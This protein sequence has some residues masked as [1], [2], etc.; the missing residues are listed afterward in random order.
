[1]MWVF[2]GGPRA[3]LAQACQGG[4]FGGAVLVRYLWTMLPLRMTAF[5]E[6]R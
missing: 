6:L 5:V 1:M 3:K 2:Y 4:S